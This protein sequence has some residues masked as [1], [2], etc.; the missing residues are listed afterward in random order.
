M[1]AKTLKLNFV[2][3]SLLFVKFKRSVFTL[4]LKAVLFKIKFKVFST[5]GVPVLYRFIS[6]HCETATCNVVG[7]YK[8]FTKTTVA[9]VL[10]R[11]AST[12]RLKHSF[13]L[14]TMFMLVVLIVLIAYLQPGAVSVGSWCL[15]L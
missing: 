2:V 14:L 10:K 5:G 15:G 4:I 11:S 8:M 3:P 9:D 6:T 12:K 1:C 13:T 7:V